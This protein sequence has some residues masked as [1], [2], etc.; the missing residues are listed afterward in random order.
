MNF[1]GQ[2]VEPFQ[3]HAALLGLSP[4]QLASYEQAVVNA[5][6]ALAQATAAKQ[7]WKTAASLAA[8]RMRELNRV[9]TET[10]TL[11]DL[12]AANA[13]DPMEL[14][15]AAMLTPPNT[16][17]VMAAPGPC[18]HLRATLNTDGSLTIQWKCKNPANAH[19]TIYQV[20]RRLPSADGGWGPFTQV[21]LAGRKHFRDG[22][23]P[24]GVGT[25]QYTVQARRVDVLG[26]VCAPFTVQ[27][28]AGALTAGGET[29]GEA[30]LAA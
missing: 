21:A 11:I 22:T 7:A 18:T 4:Q 20:L 12:N 2:H 10:V 16:P 19:G 3:Q 6:D 14:Y 5:Q 1:A 29:A 26:P 8:T 9:M 28:G 25:V 24:A 17:G 23:L 15:Q 13:A 27:L 30:R